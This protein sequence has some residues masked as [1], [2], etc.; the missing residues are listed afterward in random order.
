VV[1]CPE[2]ER[3]VLPGGPAEKRGLSGFL[4]RSQGQRRIASCGA[5]L[6]EEAIEVYKPVPCNRSKLGH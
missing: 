2:L 3:H 1:D 6:F 5:D 4:T